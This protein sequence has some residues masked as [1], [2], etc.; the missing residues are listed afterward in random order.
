MAHYS[1][2]F[3]QDEDI[4]PDSVPDIN[5]LMESVLSSLSGLVRDS[6]LDPHE[7]EGKIFYYCI[8]SSYL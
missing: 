1:V 8:N 5:L 3:P 7:S 2:Q 4:H 6:E